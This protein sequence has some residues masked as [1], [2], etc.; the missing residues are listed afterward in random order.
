MIFNIR[1]NILLGKKYLL[2]K[3]RNTGKRISKPIKKSVM[4][5]KVELFD[6][7]LKNIGETGIF[8]I[9]LKIKFGRFEF[10]ERTR[11]ESVDN[12]KYLI[13]KK[14]KTIFRPYKTVESNLSFT[15]EKALFNYEI[16]SLD[17]D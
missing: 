1:I 16:T 5:N 7:E 13:N 4:S 11:Y 2:I 10:V 9:Y 8:D 3:H 17:S 14:G 15:L 12:N 6:Q